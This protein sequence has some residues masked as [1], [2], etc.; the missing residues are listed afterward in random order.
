MSAEVSLPRLEEEEAKMVANCKAL[1]RLISVYAAV[2]HCTA[3][4]G[5]RRG[6][7]PVS[8]LYADKC[9]VGEDILAWLA[10]SKSK[11]KLFEIV[12]IVGEPV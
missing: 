9:W 10:L 2:A 6:S 3:R 8:S 11:T 12:F 1:S 7:K 4:E 5:E